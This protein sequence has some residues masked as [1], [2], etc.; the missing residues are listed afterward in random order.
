MT[1][2]LHNAGAGRFWKLVSRKGRQVALAAGVEV[3]EGAPL[4]NMNIRQQLICHNAY[5]RL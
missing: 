4:A 2:R 5:K 3:E 1:T